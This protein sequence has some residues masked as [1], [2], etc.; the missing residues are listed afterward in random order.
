MVLVEEPSMDITLTPDLETLVVQRAH[1]IGVS[2][3][4]L[5]LDTLRAQLRAFVETSEDREATP[6]LADFLGDAIGSLRSGMVVDGGAR[7][8]EHARTAF[9]RGLIDKRKRNHL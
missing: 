3:E 6:S 4:Q 1:A 5:V 9:V 7:M 2:P 8:S